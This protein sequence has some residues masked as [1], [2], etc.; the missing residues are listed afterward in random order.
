MLVLAGHLSVQ[1]TILFVLFGTEILSSVFFRAG[2]SHTQRLFSCV[3][4]S[5]ASFLDYLVFDWRVIDNF[6]NCFT[7]RT[8]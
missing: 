6:L 2:L 3:V 5:Y 1:I 8:T 7:S 4:L